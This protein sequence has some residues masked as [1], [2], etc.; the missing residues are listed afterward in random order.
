MS[1]ARRD[2]VTVR[3]R[4]NRKT[5]VGS[6]LADWSSVQPPPPTLVA[7]EV[8]TGPTDEP[9]PDNKIPWG[10]PAALVVAE[11]LADKGPAAVGVKVTTMSHELDGRTGAVV[12]QAFV[13]D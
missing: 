3:A 4:N 10:L 1:R 5:N 2:A 11:T 12:V 7:G 9:V 8:D 6:N 13:G